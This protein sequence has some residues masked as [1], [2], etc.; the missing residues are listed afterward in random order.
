MRVEKMT[1]RNTRASP[2]QNVNVNVR[3]ER[4]MV[5]EKKKR[6]DT[7]GTSAHA[8]HA[9]QLKLRRELRGHGATADWSSVDP[10]VLRDAVH[11]V[12]S[13][14]MAIM[15][16]LTRDGSAYTIRYIGENAPA[17]EYVRP[18]EDI[19]LHLTGVTQDFD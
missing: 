14:G 8:D 1:N 4:I 7:V 12:T 9:K 15:F 6:V 2:L 5:S 17:P 18:T 16:G 10:G 3:K 19:D 11:A 13:K